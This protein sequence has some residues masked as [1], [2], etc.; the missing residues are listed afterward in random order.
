MEIPL[1]SFEGSMELHEWFQRLEEYFNYARFQCERDKTFSTMLHLTSQAYTWATRICEYQ[2]TN[3]PYNTLEELNEELQLE[4]KWNYKKKKDLQVKYYNNIKEEDPPDEEIDKESDEDNN[5]DFNSDD[6]EDC[7][8]EEDCIQ[9]GNTKY[10]EPD[11]EVITKDEQFD[12][13]YE[14]YDEDYSNKD[15]E[16]HEDKDEEDH[17]KEGFPELESPPPREHED[18]EGDHIIHVDDSDNREMDHKENFCDEED[19]DP[20]LYDKPEDAINKD[21][22]V[23]GDRNEDYEDLDKNP[24]KEEDAKHEVFE[25]EYYSN[26]NLDEDPNE[27]IGEQLEGKE[28]CSKDE[29]TK[30]GQLD[31][32]YEDHE[33][34][35]DSKYKEPDEEPN[36]GDNEGLS[37][38]NKD[39]T[40]KMFALVEDN[41]TYEETSPKGRSNDLDQQTKEL[42]SDDNTKDDL[43]TS[44]KDLCPL[45]REYTCLPPQEAIDATFSQRQ[46]YAQ[47]ISSMA[48]LLEIESNCWTMAYNIFWRVG[49]DVKN[50]G[51]SFS[52][53]RWRKS[54]P[55]MAL[56]GALRLGDAP[57]WHYL[58]LTFLHLYK[59]GSFFCH[60]VTGLWSMSKIPVFVSLRPSILKECV[61]SYLVFEVEFTLLTFTVC[62]TSIFLCGLHGP[63][64][65]SVDL[66]LFLLPTSNPFGP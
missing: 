14:N 36:I 62:S 46:I 45:L 4:E 1:Y 58:W 9:T 51:I 27:D 50:Q 42:G 20:D 16:D 2:G 35:N 3:F 11:E 64:Q 54:L 41:P 7:H 43:V 22:D 6:Y 29:D 24:N 23:N 49:V 53:F 57:R 5:E 60:L 65:S 17:V 30:D 37:I 28:N 34:G 8:K 38:D 31:Q 21:V 39:E 10:E 59:K 55:N 63:R 33:E 47:P 48:C 13:G 40:D 15:L 25:E 26:T 18:G 52:S 12:E 32:E 19:Y 56:V 44:T 66:V 61:L